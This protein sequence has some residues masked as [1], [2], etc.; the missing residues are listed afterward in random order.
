MRRGEALELQAL[1]RET[2]RRG[3]R[4]SSWRQCRL[5]LQQLGLGELVIAEAVLRCRK[6][7]GVGPTEA[8]EAIV[9]ALDDV[10]SRS[11]S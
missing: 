7:P 5:A 11:S 8:Y 10:A 6:T 4:L 1:R 3:V 9:E 2:Q